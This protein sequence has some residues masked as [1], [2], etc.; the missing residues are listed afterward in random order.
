MYL[1]FH[2]E[3]PSVCHGCSVNWAEKKLE[4]KLKEEAES[5]NP[6]SHKPKVKKPVH[7][8]TEKTTTHQIMTTPA[9]RR[10]PTVPT[11]G[12]IPTVKPFEPLYT[13]TPFHPSS[14]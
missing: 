4:E 10:Y 3:Q 14:S 12:A 2:G 9:V 8:T 6:F 13:G 11:R 5:I 1:L 7:T